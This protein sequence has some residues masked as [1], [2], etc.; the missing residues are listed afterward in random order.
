MGRWALALTWQRTGDPASAHRIVRP[1]MLCRY[2]APASHRI[3]WAR[4]TT[5]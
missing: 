4:K 3:D 1:E 2:Y 5:G